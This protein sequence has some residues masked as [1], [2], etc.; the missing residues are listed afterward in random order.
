ME[1]AY[2]Y[3]AERYADTRAEWKIASAKYSRLNRKCEQARRL[4][5]ALYA[6]MESYREKMNA[7]MDRA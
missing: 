3:E 5:D 2:N 1:M 6:Q 4:S 7:E